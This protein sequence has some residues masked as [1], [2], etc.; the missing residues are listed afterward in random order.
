MA[1]D[2]IE[3]FWSEIRPPREPEPEP[4]P[5]RDMSQ[6][7]KMVSAGHRT[8]RNIT[9]DL[10]EQQL[11]RGM[12]R[13]RVLP[14]SQWVRSEIVSV[15]P[16]T[17]PVGDL[18]D[19]HYPPGTPERHSADQVR[20]GHPQ[21][22]RALLAVSHAPQDAP[23]TPRT[24]EELLRD[25]RIIGVSLDDP[26]MV[27]G[28]P[29][30]PPWVQPLQRLR[31]R[32]NSLPI[33]IPPVAIV[34]QL[35]QSLRNGRGVPPGRVFDP[36]R[37]QQNRE[38]YGI[39]PETEEERQTWLNAPVDAEATPQMRSAILQEGRHP[40][41]E[42]VQEIQEARSQ[43]RR[44]R[45]LTYEQQ[46]E[47]DR[48]S[49]LSRQARTDDLIRRLQTRIREM[50]SP[51]SA[52]PPTAAEFGTAIHTQIELRI[53]ERF[54][55]GVGRAINP[56]QV[57]A[58][59][60]IVQNELLPYRSLIMGYDHVTRWFEAA[61]QANYQRL[62]TQEGIDT[63][64]QHLEDYV[65]QATLDELETD[66][67]ETDEMIQVPEEQPRQVTQAER[68]RMLELVQNRVRTH[69]GRDLTPE[70]LHNI[71][72]IVEEQI[73]PQ[74]FI[75]GEE[76]HNQVGRENAAQLIPLVDTRRV[77]I[78]QEVHRRVRAATAATLRYHLAMSEP[79]PANII[80]RLLQLVATQINDSL[81]TQE[82]TSLIDSD[83]HPTYDD[84]GPEWDD[85]GYSTD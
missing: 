22:V 61:V 56:E 1:E 47:V 82:N 65:S 26:H 85:T 67:L 45:E 80:N 66:E 9:P 14:T 15:Q 69:L 36:F 48:H 32:M 37:S 4:K 18:F 53:R 57:A 63:L 42:E 16:L 21:L 60:R 84:D 73:N 5:A 58:M 11:I 76:E 64:I 78:A 79:Y 13:D 41:D 2:D 55:D 38:R 39:P 3:E 68:Q 23:F 10:L 6:F 52:T 31:V 29:P 40:S 20:S 46:E 50:R 24:P 33:N 74:G 72:Q 44:E 83:Q 19:I 59:E 62:S 49:I 34:D 30:E 75:V 8:G 43:L 51:N 77:H 27:M 35:E 17:G 25:I 7:K 70:E 28:D 54:Q 71:E 81:F 12:G